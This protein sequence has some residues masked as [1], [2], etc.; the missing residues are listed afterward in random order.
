MQV[1]KGK[2]KIIF[3]LLLFLSLTT[4]EFNKEK[5]FF[6]FKI[7]YV[8]FINNYHLEENIKYKIINYL[9]N[10]S[11]L[12]VN[13]KKIS[14]FLNKSQWVENFKVKKNYPNKIILH[15][16]EF[17]PIAVFQK[18]EKLYFINSNYEITNK[19]VKKQNNLKKIQ[20][21]GLYQKEIFKNKFS[22]I[23][24]YEIY[25]NIKSINI[26]NL[27]RL[28]IYLKNN[29]NIKL[30]DYDIGLQMITLTKI[31]K[32]YKNLISIDLRNKGRV[33]IK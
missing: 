9:E 1:L 12:N 21:S 26:L 18:R 7:K 2:N 32:K 25:N 10:K 17:K 27:N 22:E 24:K 5:S 14:Y 20:I 23:K 4:Y 16:N 28:D 19:I 29:T 3:F 33:V 30:G 6:L 13:D 31:M 15:I 8:Q 11:L